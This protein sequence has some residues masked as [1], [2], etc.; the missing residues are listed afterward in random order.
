MKPLSISVRKE[1]LHKYQ[2]EKG[3]SFKKLAQEMNVSVGAIQNTIKR[4]KEH[5]TLDDLPGRG[6]KH[7]LAT[8][9]LNRKLCSLY[10]S[11]PSIS[12]REAAKKLQTS[13]G[14]V[15]KLKRMNNL[16]PY[17]ERIT[18]KRSPEQHQMALSRSRKLYEEVLSNFDGCIV[19]DNEIYV[20]MDY[21]T[22]PDPEYYTACKDNPLEDEPTIQGEIFGKKVVIWQAICTCGQRS[23]TF[24]T[25]ESNMNATLYLEECLKKRLLPFIRQHSTSTIFWPNLTV[26]RYNNSVL[27][28]YETENINFV[29]KDQNPLN[30]PELRPV[31]IYL[32]QMKI[33]LKLGRRSGTTI[34]EMHRNWIWA[35]N[36]LPDTFVQNLT[37]D[38]KAK[39]QEFGQQEIK[40]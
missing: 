5:R 22:C 27:E 34:D 8:P 17:S 20:K 25:N 36:E 6:R 16:K 31:E 35:Q 15:C 23:G 40:S 38:A 1:I 39:V 28:W 33:N 14:T 37:K 2:T 3:L 30:C 29:K 21:T 7:G 10:A 32:A 18:P 13:I 24:I 4:Y 19:M 9:E 26:C 12:V 11:N